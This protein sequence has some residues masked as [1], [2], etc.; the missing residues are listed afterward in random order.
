MQVRLPVGI[1]NLEAHPR[2]PARPAHSLCWLH[3][4][5]FLE[6]STLKNLVGPREGGR[7]GETLMLGG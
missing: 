6:A 7:E 3:H 5:A 2:I 1:R 4:V